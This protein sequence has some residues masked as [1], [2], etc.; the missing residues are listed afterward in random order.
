MR[1]GWITVWGSAAAFLLGLAVGA[2]GDSKATKVV[3]EQ[4]E[5]PGEIPG[6]Q[7]EALQQREAELDERNIEL[8]ERSTELDARE[9]ALQKEEQ[10]VAANTIGEG[11]WTVGVDIEPGTYRATDVSS[12][13]YWEIRQTGVTGFEGVINNGLPGGGNPS[14]TLS[15]GQDFQTNRCGEW[16]KQ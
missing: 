5:V 4:V 1:K 13:C 7:R 2:V 15:E 8:D 16:T 11:V 10:E 9:A 14:V 12:M 3:T 6:E